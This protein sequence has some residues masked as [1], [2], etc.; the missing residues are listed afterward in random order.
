VDGA[1]TVWLN[2]CHDTGIRAVV[3]ET[4]SGAHRGAQAYEGTQGQAI[5]A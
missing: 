5:V 4:W 1:C 2:G 3:E